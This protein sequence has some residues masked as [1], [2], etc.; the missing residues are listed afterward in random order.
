M[1]WNKPLFFINY[2]TSVVIAIENGLRGRSTM[3]TLRCPRGEDTAE[4]GPKAENTRV[5][6]G[7]LRGTSWGSSWGWVIQCSHKVGQ[8]QEGPPQLK[9]I[10]CHPQ[11]RHAKQTS[12]IL[13]PH[14]T[15]TLVSLRKWEDECCN[16]HK[17]NVL[18]L[19]DSTED[20]KYFF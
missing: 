17:Y 10:T 11:I 1:N 6:A 19:W 4:Y 12:T 2:P 7:F 16:L 9:N 5:E 20:S 8:G 18:R 14:R 3:K 13:C 15:A